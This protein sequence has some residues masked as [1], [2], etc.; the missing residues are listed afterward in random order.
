MRHRRR[1]ARQRRE[2][3]MRIMEQ[4][5]HARADL[6]PSPFMNREHTA[7]PVDT[8]TGGINSSHSHTVR[9]RSLGFTRFLKRTK[10]AK[11]VIRR[12]KTYYIR[13][14]TYRYMVGKT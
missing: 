1:K 8:H 14:Y 13:L 6:S 11:Y 7:P 9:F 2:E 12:I 5:R 4:G 10:T 3:Q